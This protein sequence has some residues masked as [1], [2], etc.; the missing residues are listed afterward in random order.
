MSY[1]PQY[2]S[3]RC[4]C[5]HDWT[6]HHR[7]ALVNERALA[8]LPKGRPPYFLEEC[9]F[10]DVNEGGGMGP[11]GRNHCQHYVDRD[12]PEA[13]IRN[14]PGTYTRL[15]RAAAWGRTLGILVRVLITG[16]KAGYQRDR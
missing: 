15:E 11:D 12:D 4:R 9:E 16:K 10:Y 3:G 14:G 2:F 8:E 1:Q 6:S 13:S 5:G 7:N